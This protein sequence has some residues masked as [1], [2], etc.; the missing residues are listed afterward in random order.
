MDDRDEKVK[1][2]LLELAGVI[3]AVYQETGFAVRT[4]YHQELGK[5]I[6]TLKDQ[7]EKL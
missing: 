2:I 4:A 1:A 3:A 7:V 5:R 6:D